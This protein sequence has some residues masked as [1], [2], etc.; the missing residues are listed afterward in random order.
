MAMKR[1]SKEVRKMRDCD[2]DG[3]SAEPLDDTLVR[4]TAK[5]EGP[6]GTVYEGGTFDLDVTF[7]ADYPIKPPTIMFATKV[8]HVS[9]M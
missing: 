8:Y 7:P 2:K 6:E 1:L 3:V 9:R 5:I 4:W